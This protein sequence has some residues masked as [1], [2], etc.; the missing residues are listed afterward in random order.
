MGSCKSGAACVLQLLLTSLLLTGLIAALLPAPGEAEVPVPYRA[1]VDAEVIDAFRPPTGPYGP[2]NRGIDYATTPGEEVY[3]AG[4]GEVTF[5]ARVG[6]AWHVVILHAD[7][8]RTS[9]SFLTSVTRRRGD[10]VGQGDLVGTAGGPFHFGARAGDQYI[11]PAALLTRD[12]MPEVALIPV[13]QRGPQSEARERRGLLGQLGGALLGGL[14]AAAGVTDRTLTW[15]QGAT[16]DVARGTWTLAEWVAAIGWDHAYGE[17]MQ[18]GIQLQIAYLYLT[19]FSPA[20]VAL[21]LVE[22]AR[23]AWRF[24]EAQRNCTPSD[25]PVPAPARTRRIMVMV[26]GLDS[27]GGQGRL[28]G[29]R[30]TAL[31]YADADIVEFSY[32]GGRTGDVGTASGSTVNDYGP[33]DT[34]GDL[35]DQAGG[36]RD[37]LMELRVANPGVAV[38]I[39]AHSQ[40]GLVARLALGNAGDRLDPRLPEVSNLVMLGAPN[41]GSDVATANALLGTTVSGDIVRDAVDVL[42]GVPELD[43]TSLGQL[44]EGSAL[45]RDLDDQPLPAGTRITSI[46]AEGDLAVAS[47]N[48]SLEGATNVLVPIRGPR[49]HTEMLSSPEARRE[50]ALAL[51][52]LGPTCRRVSAGILLGGAISWGTDSFGALA[53]AAAI[54]ADHQL[55][56]PPVQPPDLSDALGVVLKG[57]RR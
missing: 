12:V 23:R 31:G 40:G 48:S 44:A 36:L 10:R 4:G 47:L 26:N 9:Y 33:S 37:L 57:R 1:P 35:R 53:G 7:G 2:G 22:Q 5:S 21:Y 13:E 42:P 54:Y 8:I 34:H 29:L 46:A 41:H 56:M 25:R 39:V 24:Q 6:P 18:V 17:L 50:V 15:L 49:A 14:S 45:M 32:R 55:G 28:L 38:D 16:A 11:D 43:A 3:A 19:Q 27:N 20:G 30:P 51:A 52:G